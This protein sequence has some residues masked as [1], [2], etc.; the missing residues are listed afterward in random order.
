MQ[1]T[2]D[3]TQER[4]RAKI[5]DQHKWDL[6]AIYPSLEAWHAA[7]EKLVAR[8]ASVQEFQGKL[9]SSAQV[10]ADALESETS[11]EKELVRVSRYAGLLADQD[12]R[13]SAHQAMKQEMVQIM[14]NFGAARAYMEPEILQMD[15]ATIDRFINKEPR[16]KVYQHIL[17]DIL[18]RREHTGSDTEERLLAGA[19][20]MANT[21]YSVFDIFSDAEFP[22]PSVELSDRKSVKLDKPAYELHRASPNRADRKK[23]MSEFF[24]SLG[25]YRATYG[26]LMNGNLQASVFYA[27]SHKYDTV[28][29]NALDGPNIPISVYTR[30]IR[31]EERRV[32]KE[33]RSRWSP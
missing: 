17:D 8:I 21:P 20:V 22:Y 27:R 11:L 25:K 6:T 18:R 10:L 15:R 26:A 7:K 32:G 9:A 19:S 24:E 31:S 13:E 16:L 28:L 3:L 1:T 14:A 5:P 30:L 12:T 23:V 4:D 29:E 33:C 2:V